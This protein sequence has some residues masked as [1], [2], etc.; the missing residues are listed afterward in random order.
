[1]KSLTCLLWSLFP[2]VVLAQ[3]AQ[4]PASTP[5]ESAAPQAEAPPTEAPVPE[6]PV[7]TTIKVR[8]HTE[9]GDIVL[10][11]EVER[12]PI[13]ATNFLRYVD[14]KRMDGMGFYRAMKLD[15][16]GNYGMVQTGIRD[17]ARKLFKPIEH[18]PTTLTGLSHVNGA[19]SM[20]RTAPGTAVADFF[21]IVGNLTALDAQPA[22]VST[23]QADN[24]G[25]AVFGG[26]IEGMEVVK[27]I[28]EQPRSL[29]AGE[30]AMKGQML[31][32]PVKVL[33]V[34]RE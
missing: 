4:V 27:A 28:M 2:V 24:L 22:A 25:Y 23:G 19:V 8:M 29:T 18:E 21:I 14:D 7:P 31:E 1:M 12:A 10:A 34:R 17:D 3:E 33:T 32:K 26:V 5:A 13:T 20:A 16:A 15:E 9:L 6:A 30:G 11:I